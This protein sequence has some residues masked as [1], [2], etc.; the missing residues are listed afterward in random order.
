MRT[1]KQGILSSIELISDKIII[2][3]KDDISM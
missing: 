1:T 2:E 3:Y